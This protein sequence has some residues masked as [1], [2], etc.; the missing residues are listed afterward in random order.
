M[1]VCKAV[2]V[3][4]GELLKAGTPELQ[5]L[6]GQVEADFLEVREAF[7]GVG[8]SPKLLRRAIRAELGR[9]TGMFAR[10]LHRS[11]ALWEVFRQ[12]AALA[13]ADGGRLRPAHLVVA[14][15]EQWDPVVSSAVTKLGHEPLEVLRV[16]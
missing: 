7:A 6:E 15:V 5:A 1:G 12:G 10:P 14:L 13:A 3:S 16:L 4:V 8:L 2:E 11:P 9:R